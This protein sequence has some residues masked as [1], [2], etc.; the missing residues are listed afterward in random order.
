M[1]RAQNIR[2]PG[3]NSQAITASEGGGAPQFDREKCVHCGACQWNCSKP[4]PGD[5]E[6]SNIEF[7]AGAG[8]SHSAE[9]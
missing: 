1:P 9:N 8:G 6:R 4:R 5:A 2:R 7:K 3:L